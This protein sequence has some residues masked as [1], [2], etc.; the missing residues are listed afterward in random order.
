MHMLNPG[1]DRRV[2]PTHCVC[3]H[4]VQVED[5]LCAGC[6]GRGRLG[7]VAAEASAATRRRAADGLRR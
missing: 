5:S 4:A 7:S 2:M 3:M 1:C 6:N